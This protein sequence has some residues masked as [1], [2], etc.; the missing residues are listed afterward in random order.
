ML[1]SKCDTQIAKSQWPSWASTNDLSP[2]DIPIELAM[3]TSDEVRTISLICPF[4][5]VILLPGGQFGEEG[6][7]IHFPFPVQ[8][9]INQL[10]RPLIESELI[11]STVGF[12]QR[13]TFQTLL[14]Q[15]DPHR[16]HQALLWLK[17]NNPL[18]ATISISNQPQPF[19]QPNQ[20]IDDESCTVQV[21]GHFSESCVIPQNRVDPDIPIEQLLQQQNTAHQMLFP[22][23]A[24]PPVNM[25]QQ[26]QL[27]EHAFPVLHPK[28][29][30]GL[31]YINRS[32]RITVFS[33][34]AVQ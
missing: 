33:I 27:E 15:L 29:R 25:F 13:Q 16:I 7:V 6:S 31:G 20:S 24:A 26:E 23:L 22:H 17:T 19:P 21:T 5:K 11:L 28:G 3:V 2:D 8:L 9:L 30:F 1:C 32:Q 4:L 12:T 18:Y 34:Q 14:E 10:P